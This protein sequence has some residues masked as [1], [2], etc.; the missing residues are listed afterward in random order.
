MV[1]IKY[2]GKYYNLESGNILSSFDFSMNMVFRYDND[3]YNIR[4]FINT[5]NSLI[6]MNLKYKTEYGFIIRKKIK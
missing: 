6:I 3:I 4:N 5:Y 2:N 1:N